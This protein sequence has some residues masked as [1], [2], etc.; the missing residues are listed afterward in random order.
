M[1]RTDM[2]LAHRTLP[3]GAQADDLARRA[4]SPVCGLVP[5]LG[6][7]FRRRYGL[8]FA[9][10]ATEPQGLHQLVGAPPVRPGSLHVGACG[11]DVDDTRIRT[12][13]ESVERYSHFAFP[14]HHRENFVFAARSDLV[15]S[16]EPVADTTALDVYAELQFAEPDF[17][18]DRF[19]PN[20]PMSWMRMTSLVGGEDVLVPAQLLLVGYQIRDQ[21]PYVQ[22]AVTTGTAVHTDPVKALLNALQELVQLDT[23][24][25]HWHTAVP[26]VRIGWDGRTRALRHLVEE[27]W[28]PRFPDPEFH[29]LPSPDLPGFTVVCLVRGREGHGPAI[30]LG[31]GTDGKLTAAM[32]KALVEASAMVALGTWQDGRA[33][34]GDGFFDLDSNIAHYS[35]PVNA[36]VVEQR[37]ANCTA[38]QASDLPAD[39]T[40]D[41]SSA[42]RRLVAAF[43]DTGK[44]L[45]HAD[46]TTP[47]VHQLGFH[48]TRVWS[49][50]VLLLSLPGAPPLRHPRFEAYGGFSNQRP[51]PYP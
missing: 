32:Y 22:S 13:A 43:R 26:S 12:I 44:Q 45:L 34:P 38:S 50:D 37:F 9:L 51:H 7:T 25:G 36:R 35:D 6:T 24:M 41:P 21:E 33:E 19:D 20:A 46:L 30:V 17:P 39:T 29:L 15:A 11:P 4:V 3:K 47:D 28:S 31:L 49:P 27:H 1:S 10:T 23:V 48:A 8:R 16:G 14:A 42:A 2:A 5:N 40:T 18:F